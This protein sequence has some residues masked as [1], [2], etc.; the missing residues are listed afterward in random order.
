M[1][2][3]ALAAAGCVPASGVIASE[4]GACQ[5]P[6]VDGLVPVELSV[7]DTSADR[8]CHEKRTFLRPAEYWHEWA[9]QQSDCVLDGGGHLSFVTTDGLCASVSYTCTDPAYRDDP[10]TKGS[11]EDTPACCDPLLEAL[12]NTSCLSSETQ[13][14]WIDDTGPH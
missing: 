14:P 8:L 9:C 13:G 2:R 10:W 1:I 6:V 4:P 7:V 5:V 11:C 3:W 12:R